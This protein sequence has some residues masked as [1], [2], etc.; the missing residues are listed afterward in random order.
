MTSLSDVDFDQVQEQLT[1]RRLRIMQIFYSVLVFSV[2]LLLV[3]FLFFFAMSSDAMMRQGMALNSS[4]TVLASI[5][6][7]VTV[8]GIIGGILVYRLRL[9]RRQLA[10]YAAKPMRE[11]A[12]TVTDPVE[13]LL[14]L[15][16][17]AVIGRGV[18]FTIPALVS[19]AIALYW[20]AVGYLQSHPERLVHLIP[21]FSQLA[22]LG[23][24]WPTRDRVLATVQA[25][26]SKA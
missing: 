1:V 13:K 14:L 7:G 4:V 17:S 11:G 20:I 6:W 19:A 23:S 12:I 15:V 25:I 2:M 10:S 3:M 26:V 18:L 8:V 24:T 9:G 5:I 21:A 22:F 16:Q